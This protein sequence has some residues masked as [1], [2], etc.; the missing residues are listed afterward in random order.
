MKVAVTFFINKRK[1]N[2]IRKK[3]INIIIYFSNNSI[4]QQ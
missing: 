2:I 3:Y 4:K 1:K